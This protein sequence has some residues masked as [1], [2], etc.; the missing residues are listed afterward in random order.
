MSADDVTNELVQ[1]E[2]K[3]LFNKHRYL[4]ELIDKNKAKIGYLEKR[5][6]FLVKTVEDLQ[7]K[8]GVL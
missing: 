3:E 4:R 5:V 7:E 6:V 8:V 1:G 2:L